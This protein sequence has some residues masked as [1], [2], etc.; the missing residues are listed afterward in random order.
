MSMVCVS[1]KGHKNA[2]V[3]GFHLWPSCHS[4]DVSQRGYGDLGGLHIRGMVSSWPVL[5]AHAMSTSMALLQPGTSV[6][7]L[8][9]VAIEG[10]EDA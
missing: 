6:V 5:L 7:S 10:Y 2:Q 4:R 3:M 8:T 9:P 1:T